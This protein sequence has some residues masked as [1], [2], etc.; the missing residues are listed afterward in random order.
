MS[1]R[2]A[3]TTGRSHRNVAAF[4]LALGLFLAA[5]APS[6][7]AAEEGAKAPGS[8]TQPVAGRREAPPPLIL[9]K[10]ASS[11]TLWQLL[12]YT[13]ILLVLAGAAIFLVRRFLPKIG[14][15]TGKNVR[16]LETVHLGP[17][18]TVHL[19][20]VGSRTYLVGGAR[21]EISMLADVTEAVGGG[22]QTGEA[23]AAE[24]AG[25]ADT[26]RA[27]STELDKQ[28]RDQQGRSDS[29]AG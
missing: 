1:F 8:A 28:Q 19:L 5:T 23:L 10:E 20:R 9:K 15:A 24:A 4:S 2:C 16:V 12:A 14:V 6:E 11:G 25:P 13:L 3:Y 7:A 22:E 27:F 26:R 29:D 17:R 21:E 18:K